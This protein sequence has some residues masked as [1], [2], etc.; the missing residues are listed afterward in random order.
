M[1]DRDAFD[2]DVERL[3]ARPPALEDDAV[4]VRR[5]EHRL[6]RRWRVRAVVLTVAGML[7][8]VLAVREAVEAGLGGSLVRLS[9]ESGRAVQSARGL[10]WSAALDWLNGGGPDLIGASTMPAFWLISAGLIAAALFTAFRANEA[11]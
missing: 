3:F 6:N 1:S 10:D 5:V 7:G 11:S 4:F 8:G 2:G 9:E